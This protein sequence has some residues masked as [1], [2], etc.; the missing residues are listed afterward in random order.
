MSFAAIGTA[1]IAGGTAL[2]GAVAGGLAAVGLPTIGAGLGTSIVGLSGGIGGALTGGGLGALGAGLGT[3]G[4]GLG[5]AAGAIP[6]IGGVAAPLLGAAGGLLGGGVSAL[7]GGGLAALPSLGS[8]GIGGGGS[9]LLGQLGMSGSS[10]FGN[11]GSLAGGLGGGGGGGVPA[12][13]AVAGPQ[14]GGGVGGGFGGGIT[15]PAIGGPSA[16]PSVYN[17]P[18]S[19]LGNGI[20]GNGVQYDPNAPPRNYSED[21][22]FGAGERARAENAQITAGIQHQADAEAEK[23]NAERSALYKDLYGFLG[24]AATEAAD[25]GRQQE[26]L[27]Y[28]AARANAGG[29]ITRYGFGA[30]FRSVGTEALGALAQL[31]QGGQQ[32]RF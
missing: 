21:A 29:Q 17:D 5:I 31:A 30:P 9:G 24:S 11:L 28:E 3:F 8:L 7:G 14:A 2:G 18:Y 4:G 20:P 10:L 23:K 16:Q 22:I 12:G 15:P 26:L 13:G 1:I 32:G 19:Q 25:V 6:G 27:D